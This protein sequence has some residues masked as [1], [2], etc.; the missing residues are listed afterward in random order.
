MKREVY[1]GV[2]ARLSE[3]RLVDQ[4][5]FD[6]VLEDFPSV[7][8]DAVASI[9]SQYCVV[10]LKQAY[11]VHRRQE[12]LDEHCKRWRGGES[13]VE[14]SEELDFPSCSLGRLL[15]PLLTACTS[16]GNGNQNT[17][18]TAT[19]VLNDPECLLFAEEEEDTRMGKKDMSFL[20]RLVI[21]LKACIARDHISSP[22]ISS[23][24]RAVGLEYEALLHRVLTS[25]GIA[26]ESESQL[27]KKGATKTPDAL[28]KIPFMLGNHVVHWI[29]SKACF[30]SDE[31][32]YNDG[33]RQFRQY[34]NRFGS[35]MVI[36]WFGYIEDIPFEESILVSDS[37][38]KQI[39]RLAV[40]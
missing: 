24:K 30:C 28:L 36:Y 32:Y 23:V 14:I 16:S 15:L 22:L 2:G 7:S 21:D 8:Y 12:K 40:C 17:R 25:A 33:I 4:P 11:G 20:K 13:L 1:H 29:D 19:K 26:Y 31:L 27:R 37:F 39:T 9:Y 10:R 18:L 3:G 35:G 34:V 38:P 6:R 5:D